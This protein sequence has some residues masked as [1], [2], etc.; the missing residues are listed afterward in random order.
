MTSVPLLVFS[1]LISYVYISR[2]GNKYD[3]SLFAPFFLLHMPSNSSTARFYERYPIPDV[4]LHVIAF[5]GG[6]DSSTLVLWAKQHLPPEKTC[7]VFCDT[8]WES[9]V[10]YKFVESMNRRFMDSKLIVLRSQ[11]YRGLVDLATKRKRFPS[12][13]ARF[14][15]EQLKIVPMIDW[16]LKQEGDL[17]IYQGI[18][19]QESAARARMKQSEDFFARQ[20]KYRED[21][22]QFRR[23]PLF[24]DQ[25]TTWL[26]RRSCKVE[27]PLF[28]WKTE[29]VL[30]ICRENDTLNPLY[31]KGFERVGCY[32][33]VMCSKKEIRLLA[34]KDPDR[35]AQIRSYEKKLG[36]TFFHHGTVPDSF[37]KEP[38][39]DDVVRWSRSEHK[40][41]PKGSWSC[42]SFYN[43]CE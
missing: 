18:R 3:P 17:A 20:I 37:C 38:W 40:G 13:L 39:I 35:I 14:C 42:M 10:T 15:T 22:K 1:F 43:H 27:R 28:Y 7:F 41:G 23:K 32:P 31:D 11:T 34:D 12:A 30:K 24:Q 8:G 36:R 9:P 2:S 4:D 29:D 19:G 26:E 5:S 25:V 33:C 16:I 21:P 6:K